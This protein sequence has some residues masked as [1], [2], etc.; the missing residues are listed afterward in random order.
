MLNYLIVILLY[1]CIGYFIGRALKNNGIVDILWGLGFVITTVYLVFMY[2]I[3]NNATLI[4]LG[5]I[6]LWGIRLSLRIYFRNK[7]KKEDFRY[8]KW[9]EE[10]GK[11]V[12]VR[13]FFQIYMLQALVMFVMM[14]PIY[15]IV[16][17]N[18]TPNYYILSVGSLIW[19]IGYIFEVV[20]DYQL[21]KFKKNIQ[22]KGK[23]MKKGLWRYTRHPNYFGEATMWWGIF[24]ISYSIAQNIFAIISP[25]LI[26]YLLL[27]VSGVPLLEKRYEGNKE[28]EKYKKETNKFFP[29]FKK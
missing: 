1:F 29:W 17:T 21:D 25:I 22:E 4:I 24:I 8:A 12:N 3:K 27:F 2:G 10:W 5:I 26:T 14:L 19:L 18:R 16:S 28:F 7:G 6:T 13:A 23:I 15:Y 9:R 11:Y 20:G